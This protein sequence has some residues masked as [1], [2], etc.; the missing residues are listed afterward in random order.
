[1]HGQPGA[2]HLVEVQAALGERGRLERDVIVDEGVEAVEPEAEA[3]KVHPHAQVELPELFGSQG[4]IA[5]DRGEAVLQDG[6]ERA[7]GV[8]FGLRRR[9][10]RVAGTGHEG[11][12]L[13]E[14]VFGGAVEHPETVVRLEVRGVE[15]LAGD[16][17]ENARRT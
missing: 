1:M 5:D 16:G 13:I 7:E 12:V 2:D 3:V 17:E 4:R 15:I 8:E 6:Q 11:P 9:P 10:F 14:L